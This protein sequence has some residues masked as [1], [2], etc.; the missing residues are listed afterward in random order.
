MMPILA[1]STGA[2]DTLAASWRSSPRSP[3]GA[4]ETEVH[5]TPTLFIDGVVHRG[6]YDASSLLSALA[7]R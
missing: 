4:G 1:G 7:G 6:D 5:G 3:T 2:L